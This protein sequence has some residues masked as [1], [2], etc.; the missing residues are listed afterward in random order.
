MAITFGVLALIYVLEGPPRRRE[1]AAAAPTEP[2]PAP[3]GA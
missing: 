3:D 1:E 2:A